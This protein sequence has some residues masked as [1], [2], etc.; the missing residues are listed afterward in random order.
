MLGTEDERPVRS[1]H[2]EQTPES[3][4]EGI[5]RAQAIVGEARRLILN[6]ALTE[7]P[8]I[9]APIPLSAQTDGKLAK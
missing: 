6:P 4:L 8:A 5:H 1:E 9:A 2:A 3:I 7:P